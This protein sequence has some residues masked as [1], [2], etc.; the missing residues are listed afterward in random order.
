MAPS[1]RIFVCVSVA[2]IPG[3]PQR[4][5]ITL[6]N[7]VCRDL[8]SWRFRATPHPAVYDH[9]HIPADFDS[10]S[11]VKRWFV[12]D[13][14]VRERLSYHDVTKL[15]HR[16]YLASRQ[17]DEWMFIQRDNWTERAKS[18]A[19]SFT[20]GGQLEQKLVCEMRKGL[21]PT[22]LPSSHS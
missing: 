16:V 15:P 11:P 4:R 9:V 17:G 20:W 3:N 12:F 1:M 2:D 21:E 14:N 18:E 13:L 22:R 10:A 6:G 8:L 7:A 19:A 5:H